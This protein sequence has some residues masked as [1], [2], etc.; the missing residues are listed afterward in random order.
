MWGELRSKGGAT[1]HK[2]IAE[3]EAKRRNEISPQTHQPAR[4]E[5]TPYD[6]LYSAI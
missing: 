1:I 2:I 3:G 4:F 6:P 5:T